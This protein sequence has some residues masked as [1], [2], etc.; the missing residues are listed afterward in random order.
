MT[1]L[2]LQSTCSVCGHA[3]I[4]PGAE[5]CPVCNTPLNSAKD[6]LG[7]A[8]PAPR[9]AASAT[10]PTRAT[11]KDIVFAALVKGVIGTAVLAPLFGA[12]FYL[13]LPG[14]ASSG[15]FG[16]VNYG[17][18]TGFIFGAI[19]GALTEAEPPVLVGVL[20]GASIGATIAVAQY[21]VE[22][23]VVATP[24]YP[25]YVYGFMGLAAGAFTAVA[26]YWY[27]QRD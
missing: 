19:W 11:P 26:A 12:I 9:A 17:A 27:R 4:S 13:A 6:V 1:P 21:A 22:S 10:G 25:V 23:A 14:E 20:L 5:N 3:P 16:G 7:D 2:A 15:F 24:D 18:L 8:A